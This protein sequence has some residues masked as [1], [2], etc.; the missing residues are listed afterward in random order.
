MTEPQFT[1]ATEVDPGATVEP[2]RRGR[3]RSQE[4]ITRDDAVVAA[5][6]EGGAK[7]RAQLTDELGVESSLVYLALWRLSRA[8]RV[9]KIVDGETRHAWRLVG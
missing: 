6:R 3:P 9:E 2:T 7:T 1:E 8:G 5:L 4:T